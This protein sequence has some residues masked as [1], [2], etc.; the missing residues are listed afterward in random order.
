MA[1]DGAWILIDDAEAEAQ[2]FADSLS[3]KG[4]IAVEVLKPAEARSMLLSGERHPAGILV[5]VDLSSIAGETGTGPGIA[6]DIR[7]KQKA[8]AIPEYPLIRFAALAPVQKNV[9]G[10]PTS[11][12]LFDLKIQKEAVGRDIDSVIAQLKGVGEIYDALNGYEKIDDKFF[13]QIL[14][15]T[16]ADLDVVSHDGF[17][18]RFLSSLQAAVH[19]AAGVFVRSFLTAPG[20]LIDKSLLAI[21]LGIDAQ[22]SGKMWPKLLDSLPFRYGGIGHT[23][24]PRWWARGLDAWWF[25][26]IDGIAPLVSLTSEQRI[27]L[28]QKKLGV[29]GLVALQLPEGSPGLHPWRLCKLC[30]EQDLPVEFPIDATDAVRLTL[31]VDLPIW[32]DPPYASLK[33]ACQE[34]DDLRVNRADISRLLNKYK[35]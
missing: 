13:R 20:L 16:E 6:Q 26:K 22:K 28:L 34:K 17:R 19:V 30:L 12:D 1:N 31:K 27:D 3:A 15:C 9:R 14:G 29:E 23:Y 21:R 4:G 10:D 25:E 18:D 5:D 32:V 24:F 8:G 11:D 33:F 2:S 7:V 35:D